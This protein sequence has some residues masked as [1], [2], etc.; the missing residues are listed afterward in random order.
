M[1][2][3]IIGNFVFTILDENNTLYFIKGNIISINN[4]QTG[5][6]VTLNKLL[7]KDW[8]IQWLQNYASVSIRP[9]T[10]ISYEE[11]VHNHIIPIL[12]DIPIQHSELL[13]P[14]V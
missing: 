6:Y 8:L 4:K 12:D 1:V 11:Y 10:Y 13:Q 14:E 7:L 3:D 9:S 2:E 5:A